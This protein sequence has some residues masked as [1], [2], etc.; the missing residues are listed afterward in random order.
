M[1]PCFSLFSLHWRLNPV[2][3]RRVSVYVL[4]TR[5][6]SARRSHPFLFLSSV[7]KP[8]PHNLFFQL[9]TVRQRSNFQRG[10]LWA[11]KEMALQSPFDAYLDG[12]PLFPF[13]PLRSYFVQARG[14]AR[15]GIRL[16]QPLVQQRLELA[17][18]FEAELQG[19]KPAYRGLRKHISIERSQS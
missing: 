18:V 14:A 11:L 12:S 8:N 6:R 15:C 17:H 3:W 19:L 1:C 5:Q 10:W 16:L 9:Q 7:T 2:M 4:G 13:P